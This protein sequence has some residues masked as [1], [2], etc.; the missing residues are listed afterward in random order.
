MKQ[1]TKNVLRKMVQ[2]EMEKQRK[3]REENS[4]AANPGMTYNTP[5]F[6]SKKRYER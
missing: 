3:L 2:E 4:V 6:V 5:R 1:I